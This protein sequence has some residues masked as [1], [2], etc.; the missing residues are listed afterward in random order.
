MKPIWLFLTDFR[1]LVKDTFIRSEENVHNVF[2]YDD[3]ETGIT[4]FYKPIGSVLYYVSLSNKDE[5]LPKD[6]TIRVLKV[7]FKAMEIREQLVR[8]KTIQM[9]GTLG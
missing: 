8:H 5:E 3:P 1:G 2:Y 7:E 4:W 6:T 9:Q